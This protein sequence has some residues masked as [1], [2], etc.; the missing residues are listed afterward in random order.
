MFTGHYAAA[1]A[2]KG[3]EKGV[4]LAWLFIAVQFVDILFF[5]LASAGIEKLRF[6]DGITEANNFDLYFYPYTHGLLGT[7]LWALAF[8]LVFRYGIFRKKMESGRVAGIMF[9]AVL[10]HWFADLIVHI[11]DLPLITGDPKFGLGLWKDK[12][13]AFGVEATLLLA[14][15][16]YYLKNTAARHSAGKY[17]AFL[18][19][20]G[21]IV[22]NYLNMYILPEE[23][24]IHALTVSALF[25]FFLFAFIAGW[26]DRQRV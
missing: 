19:A 24:N 22:V 23:E 10:S 1:F 26:V 2:L 25:S 20:L 12:D 15:L 3:K 7:A 11:P 17:V 6:V 14:G 9:L 21:L 5:P 16:W 13:L 4:S 18:F 8:Y